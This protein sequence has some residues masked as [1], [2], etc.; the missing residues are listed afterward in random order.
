MSEPTDDGIKTP[1]ADHEVD[2]ES[3]RFDTGQELEPEKDREQVGR[4]DTGEELEPEKDREQTGRY[5][6]GESQN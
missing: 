1:P 2:Q 4:F 6:E 5:D 3:G